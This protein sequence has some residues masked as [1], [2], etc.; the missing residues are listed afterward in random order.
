MK[1]CRF[2]AGK[3]VYRL[4]RLRFKRWKRDHPSTGFAR[5]AVGESMMRLAWLEGEAKHVPEAD[6]KIERFLEAYPVKGKDPCEKP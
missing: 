6:R 4:A 2:E 1:P 3:V 5:V